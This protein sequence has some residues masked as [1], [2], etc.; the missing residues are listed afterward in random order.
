MW[1]RHTFYSSRGSVLAEYAC[2]AELRALVRTFGLYTA[3]EIGAC[4]ERPIAEAVSGLLAMLTSNE[5]P[6]SLLYTEYKV[7]VLALLFCWKY[8]LCTRLS[9]LHRLRTQAATSPSSSWDELGRLSISSAPV[10]IKSTKPA[11]PVIRLY[12]PRRS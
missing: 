1:R 6:L 3:R 4:T 10:N 2:K 9:S 12:C 5:E 7:H 8:L 11:D